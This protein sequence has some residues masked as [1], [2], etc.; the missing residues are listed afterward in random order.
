MLADYKSARTD[1]Q[2]EIRQSRSIIAD[3]KW[4]EPKLA[5]KII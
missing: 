1:E 5:L 2:V 4:A 3:V